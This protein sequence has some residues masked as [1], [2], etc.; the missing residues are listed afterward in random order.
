MNNK[1]S[2][3]KKYDVIVL[4]RLLPGMEGLKICQKLREQ[5][6]HTPILIL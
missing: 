6:N 1:K 5:K 4:D 2:E 3:G